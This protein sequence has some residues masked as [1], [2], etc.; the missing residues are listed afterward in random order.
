[1]TERLRIEV[2]ADRETREYVA[3]WDGREY[4]AGNPF[5]LDSKLLDAGVPRPHDLVLVGGDWDD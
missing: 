3:E 4:R 1:M 5:G 2:R